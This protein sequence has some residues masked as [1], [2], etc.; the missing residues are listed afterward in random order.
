M[1]E[2]HFLQPLDVLYLRGNRLFGDSSATGEAIMPP[3]PSLAAGALRSQLLVT[4][5]IDVGQFAENNAALSGALAQSLGTP[6]Q[7]GDFRISH[8]LLGRFEDQVAE[9]ADVYWPLPAD[10]VVTADT[11]GS[12]QVHPLQPH[13]LPLAIQSSAPC[14]QIPVLR[15]DKQVKPESGLWLNLEGMQAWLNSQVIEAKHLVE[16]RTLW[17]IDSRLGIAL[18]AQARTTSDGQ[19]YTVDAVALNSDIGFL[20]GIAGCAGLLPKNG[21]LRLGGDGRAARHSHVEWQAPRPNWQQ[22]DNDKRFKVLLTTPGLFGQGWLLPGMMAHEGGYIWKTADF[23]AHFV[24]ATINRAET[25]SGWDIAENKPK[26]ALKAVSTGSVY[27]FD[28]FEGDIGALE[29]LVEQSLFELEVYPDHKRR[30]EGFNNI[31]IGNWA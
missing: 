10:V 7:P 13:R 31:N 17:N 8:F 24:T 28:H 5:G 19:L 3:W 4:G 16:T 11:D 1:T 23:S 18:D 25:I 22:I 21:A 30:A 27:W 20:V 6:T 14:E 29:K 15:T 26:P 2:Y 9:L 12:K